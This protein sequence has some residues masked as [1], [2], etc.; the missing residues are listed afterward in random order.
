[1]LSFNLKTFKTLSA[2]C[3]L[4]RDINIVRNIVCRLKGKLTLRQRLRFFENQKLLNHPPLGC[5][6]KPTNHLKLDKR[7]QRLLYK[8]EITSCEA[9]K[10]QTLGSSKR[11]IVA[12]KLC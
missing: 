7:R 10:Q 4:G 9:S 3:D 12:P 1:M 8:K 2:E 6:F 11:C 5:N